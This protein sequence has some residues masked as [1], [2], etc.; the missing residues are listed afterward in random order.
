MFSKKI[1]S[2]KINELKDILMR[3]KVFNCY[4]YLQYSLK[5]GELLILNAF[6]SPQQ[7]EET[8]KNKL[9]HEVQNVFCREI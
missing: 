8:L 5:I 7:G 2:K 4:I 9:K 3:G 1:G 6:Y